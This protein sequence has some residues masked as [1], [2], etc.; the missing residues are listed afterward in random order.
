VKLHWQIAIGIILGVAA[1]SAAR[2]L[3]GGSA[4]IADWIHPFGLMFIRALK[5]VAI[6]LVIVSMMKGITDLDNIKNLS[7]IGGRTLMWFGGTTLFS[8]LL[9]VSLAVIFEPGSYISADTLDALVSQYDLD[10]GADTPSHRGPLTFLVEIIPENIFEA[11][12]SNRSM[13]QVIFFTVFFSICLLTLPPGRYRTLLDIVST[14]NDVLI[15]MIELIMKTA[16]LAVF[17]LMAALVSGLTDLSL[18]KA[19]LI[20]F[21]LLLVGMSIILAVYA[22]LVRYCYSPDDHGARRKKSG[23]R[24]KDLKFCVSSRGHYPYGC[25]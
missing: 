22:I 11:F 6:P 21:I 17:A 12:S 8:V 9:G 7:V 1:G 25:Y 3:G 19:L 20:Y 2:S 13:L 24:S 4:F 10:I 14:I 23:S 5:F 18:F 15:K 16:P